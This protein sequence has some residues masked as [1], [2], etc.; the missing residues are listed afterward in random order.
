MNWIGIIEQS[1]IGGNVYFYDFRFMKNDTI[2]PSIE[3]SL[4]EE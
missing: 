1:I 4:T 2:P 3:Y